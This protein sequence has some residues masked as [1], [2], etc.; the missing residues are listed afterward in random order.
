MSI[1]L[2]VDWTTPEPG[3]ETGHELAW[4]NGILYV[5]GAPVW[6]RGARD[7]PQP[8]AWSWIDLLEFLSRRWSLITGEQG[9]LSIQNAKNP[10]ELR[11]AAIRASDDKILDDDTD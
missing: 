10:L 7:N 2:K 5:A 9:L 6:F 11:D 8:I 1:E 3:E 4:G